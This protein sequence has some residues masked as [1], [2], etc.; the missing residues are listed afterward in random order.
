LIRP[1][2]YGRVLALGVLVRVLVGGPAV[3]LQVYAKFLGSKAHDVA[4]DEHDGNV[5]HQSSLARELTA[6]MHLTL[7][8]APPFCE[9]GLTL[10]NPSR[11]GGSI[12]ATLTN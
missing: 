1:E 5:L 3:F 9:A 12:L 10:G 2:V 11:P 6:C 7:S 4:V 8:S